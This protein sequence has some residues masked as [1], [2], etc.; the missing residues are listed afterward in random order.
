M[1]EY[2]F[3]Q[4]IAFFIAI[5]LVIIAG[6]D[7]KINRSAYEILHIQGFSLLVKSTV[8]ELLTNADYNNIN[9]RVCKQLSISPF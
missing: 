9:E 3:A 4:I 8:K 2:A 1:L 5:R 6:K 7:L